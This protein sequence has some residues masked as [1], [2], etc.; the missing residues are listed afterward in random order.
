MSDAT[1]T[2]PKRP[3]WTWKTKPPET[4]RE[5]LQASV[6]FSIKG[7]NSNAKALGVRLGPSDGRDLPYVCMARAI[8][9]GFQFPLDYTMNSPQEKATV[10]KQIANVL[11]W[12][13]MAQH[14]DAPEEECAVIK[15]EFAEATQTRHF[16]FV[17]NTPISPRAR[18]VLFPT[19]EGDYV[20]LIPLPST[21]FAGFLHKRWFDYRDRNT[22]DDE[23]FQ[24][25][26]RVKQAYMGFGGSNTQNASRDIRPLQEPFVFSAPQE[27]PRVRRAFAIHHR[28]LSMRLPPAQ[29][30]AYREWRERKQ[31]KGG[32]TSDIHNRRQE[33]R[34]VADIVHALL[35]RGRRAQSILDENRAILTAEDDSTRLI[36]DDVDPVPAGL[37]DRGSRTTDW[38][39]QFAEMTARHIVNYVFRDGRTLGLAESAVRE[40]A[41]WIEEEVRHHEPV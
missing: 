24:A 7:I 21:V 32:I 25:S 14:A 37:A 11:G 8:A 23:G 4:Y 16:E 9:D 2:Q 13:G 38:P 26:P 35:R 30:T 40:L 39:R 31:A 6:H 18:Q 5:A 17:P 27:H 41:H 3:N 33:A 12:S 15:K 10:F 34:L 22:P 28:G 1:G 20:T 29:M 19:P 36:A